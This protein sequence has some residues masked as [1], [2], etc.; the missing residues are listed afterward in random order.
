MERFMRR[1]G[2]L[3]QSDE[4]RGQ[5][6][7]LLKH[8]DDDYKDTFSTQRTWT[9]EPDQNQSSSGRIAHTSLVSSGRSM[10]GVYCLVS[11]QRQTLNRSLH[12]ELE[13]RSKSPS[14]WY[15]QNK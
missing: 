4:A 6:V 12:A 10:S 11:F 3:K 9:L 15:Q 13:D 7:T 14:I 8:N 2:M 5:D 1:L